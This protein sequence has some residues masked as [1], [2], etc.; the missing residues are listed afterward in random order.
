MYAII[1][2]FL[3]FFLLMF[4][5]DKGKTGLI[6]E[7]TNPATGQND[8]ATGQN[9]SPDDAAGL[10]YS[11]Y[12][13]NDPMILAQKNAAN[14]EYLQERLKEL[15]TLERDFTALK[16]ESDGNKSAIKKM[17]TSITTHFSRATG[18]ST[19]GPPP[20]AVSGLH[21]IS[22]DPENDVSNLTSN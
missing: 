2:A 21:T 5:M 16:S 17:A 7:V 8:S 3:L 19:T 4:V 10:K 14:I 6:E 12:T 20:K 11:S 13:N 18:I 15:Q 22:N 9:D 1:F